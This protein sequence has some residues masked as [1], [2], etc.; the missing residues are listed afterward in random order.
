[1]IHPVCPLRPVRRRRCLGVAATHPRKGVGSMYRVVLLVLLLLFAP[2]V[3]ATEMSGFLLE[4]GSHGTSAGQFDFPVDV[5]VDGNGQVY[6]VDRMN[7]RIQVFSSDGQH[8]HQWG[9]IGTGDNELQYPIGVAVATD[10]TVYVGDT[11]N[12]K[13]KV[14]SAA[15]QLQSSWGV[16]KL[17]GVSE[18]YPAE[19]AIDS[20]GNI[21]V[22]AKVVENGGEMALILKFTGS[23]EWV[24][25]WFPIP[26]PPN[27]LFSEWSGI[28]IDGNGD[29]LVADYRNKVI[30]K[31]GKDGGAPI[32]VCRG[33]VW[34]D[35]ESFRSPSDVAVDEQGHI[36]VLDNWDS[37]VQV[38][39]ETGQYLFEWGSQGSES[40]QFDDPEAF[41]ISPD[42]EIYVADSGNHRIQMFSAFTTAVQSTSWSAVKMKYK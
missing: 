12:Q 42:R 1:M 30:Q 29:I 6:V 8:L 33:Q 26:L 27:G 19:L 9:A 31:Y 5:T 4:W 38:F 22:I 7:C 39:S 37:K 13:I 23:G 40:G 3:L 11:L 15:G 16:E 41:A 18:F 25:Y 14:F 36:Y 17:P 34:G 20:A 28:T 24:D 10:G 21:Y 35:P 32:I 2:T